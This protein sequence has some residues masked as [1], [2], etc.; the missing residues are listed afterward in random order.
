VKQHNRAPCLEGQR[1]RLIR[2]ERAVLAR[3]IRM[4]GKREGAIKSELRTDSILGKN[5]WKKQR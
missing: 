5:S 3:A 4:E 2:G 1:E